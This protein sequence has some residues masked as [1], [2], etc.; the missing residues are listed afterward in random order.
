[1]ASTGD[2]ELDARLQAI[3]REVAADFVVTVADIGYRH[4]RRTAAN[5]RMVDR[6]D[7]A[8]ELD[9]MAERMLTGAETGR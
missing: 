9:A 8:L 7:L 5:A 3:F 6:E 2:P 1:M 4:I